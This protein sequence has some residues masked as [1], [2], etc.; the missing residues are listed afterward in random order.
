MHL[1][2]L[3]GHGVRQALQPDRGQKARKLKKRINLVFN[4]GYVMSVRRMVRD[5]DCLPCLI[6][7]P[8]LALLRN[9]N[10]TQGGGRGTDLQQKV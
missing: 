1:Q 5:G 7:L 6:I 9:I 8:T 3:Q 4:E 10:S 2:M